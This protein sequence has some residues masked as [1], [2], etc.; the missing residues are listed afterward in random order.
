MTDATGLVVPKEARALTSEQRMA[1]DAAFQGLPSNPTWS[2]SAS[3]IYEGLLA[4][5][6][7]KATP[8][9]IPPASASH[10]QYTFGYGMRLNEGA[11]PELRHFEVAVTWPDGTEG[12]M[13]LHVITGTPEEIKARFLQNVNAFFDIHSKS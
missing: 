8:L 9:P 4:A 2:A 6:G 13:A 1:A 3:A 11:A 10:A 5:L 7:A 12:R